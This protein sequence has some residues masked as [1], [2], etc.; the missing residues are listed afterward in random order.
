LLNR[1]GKKAQL[2]DGL[3]YCLDLPAIVRPSLEGMLDPCM[4][5]AKPCADGTQ[6]HQSAAPFLRGVNTALP[7]VT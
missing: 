4:A 5:A 1:L 6:A 7:P 3:V 2:L